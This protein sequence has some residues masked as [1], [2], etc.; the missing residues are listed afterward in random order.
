MIFSGRDFFFYIKKQYFLFFYLIVFAVSWM[1]WRPRKISMLEDNCVLLR[2]L[3]GTKYFCCNLF[4]WLWLFALATIR[5]VQ[6]PCL[7]FVTYIYHFSSCHI[8]IARAIA[9]IFENVSENNMKIYVSP[10]EWTWHQMNTKKKSSF[11]LPSPSHKRSECFSFRTLRENMTR[12]VAKEREREMGELWLYYF[13][14]CRSEIAKPKWR[15]K[16][17]KESNSKKCFEMKWSRENRRSQKYRESREPVER[18]SNND[19]AMN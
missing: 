8:R 18:F 5:F 3:T 6:R 9:Y 10:S 16:I 14:I 17:N 1:T 15:D 13:S 12:R 2:E 4:G 7:P 11:L 19:D